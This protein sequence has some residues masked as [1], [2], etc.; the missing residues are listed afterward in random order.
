M[1]SACYFVQG[2]AGHR[3]SAPLTIVGLRT[4]RNDDSVNNSEHLKQRVCLTPAS[5]SNADNEIL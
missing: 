3:E 1:C 2:H 4:Q 5:N